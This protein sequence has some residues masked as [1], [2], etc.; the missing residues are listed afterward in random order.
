MSDE[1]RDFEVDGWMSLEEVGE[2]ED[3]LDLA[4]EA[5]LKAIEAGNI[6]AYSGLAN[7]ADSE[8]EK[9]EYL[10]KAANVGR[11]DA[12]WELYLELEDSIEKYA[13]LK[14]VASQDIIADAKDEF[15]SNDLSDDKI[16]EIDLYVEKFLSDL[17]ESGME[18]GTGANPYL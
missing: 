5:F 9:I 13:M 18:L 6:G 4:K 15:D 7:L 2:E 17:K 11:L 16:K 12:M 8:Q 14:I 10:K 1:G 3:A